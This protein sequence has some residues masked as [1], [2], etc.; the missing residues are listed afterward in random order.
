MSPNAGESRLALQCWTLVLFIIAASVIEEEWQGKST[1]AV[2]VSCIHGSRL[3]QQFS[4]SYKALTSLH[5]LQ[6]SV[7]CVRGIGTATSPH[8][9]WVE[10]VHVLT[11]IQCLHD[12]LLI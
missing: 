3:P 11:W 12:S 10:A 4:W 1:D 8:V 5:D 2:P 9:E 7:V 6:Q